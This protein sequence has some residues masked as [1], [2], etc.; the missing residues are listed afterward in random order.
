M[1]FEL[2]RRRCEFAG[3]T[4]VKKTYLE[5]KYSL[6]EDE[7]KLYEWEDLIQRLF[8]RKGEIVDGGEHVPESYTPMR[9]AAHRCHLLP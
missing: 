1:R 3:I 9:V 8:I 7:K 2:S 5:A 4:E 6:N